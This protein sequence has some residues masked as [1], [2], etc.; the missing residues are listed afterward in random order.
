M[1]PGI[2]AKKGGKPN[3]STH[4]QDFGKLPEVVEEGGELSSFSL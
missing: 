2:H 3:K 4:F 1:R